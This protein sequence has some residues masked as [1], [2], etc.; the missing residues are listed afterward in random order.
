RIGIAAL[1]PSRGIDEQRK[2]RRMA[3]GETIFAE[4]FDL[5]EAA[6]GE[7]AWVTLRGHAL[8]HLAL[9]RAD[10]PHALERCHSAPQPVGLGWREPRG[11]DGDLHRLLLEQRHA[12]RLVEHA[13]ELLGRIV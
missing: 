7:L 3:L 8:D 5:V 6:L 2:T 1:E 13:L 9:E 11:H 12:E 10:R 4:A